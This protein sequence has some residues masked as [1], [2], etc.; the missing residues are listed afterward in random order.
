MKPRLLLVSYN[1]WALKQ[2]ASLNPG[3][4][5]LTLCW[6]VH[7][8]T[9]QEECNCCDIPQRFKCWTTRHCGLILLPI[10]EVQQQGANRECTK[11]WQVCR[12]ICS[13][14][15]VAAPRA[16]RPIPQR[17]FRKKI[18]NQEQRR[19]VRQKNH[20]KMT[21]SGERTI[22]DIPMS[23]LFPLVLEFYRKG[24]M[25]TCVSRIFCENWGTR[26][27]VICGILLVRATTRHFSRFPFTCHTIRGSPHRWSPWT[28]HSRILGPPDHLWLCRWFPYGTVDSFPSP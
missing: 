14:S 9:A 7:H 4:N 24:E 16:L 2:S 13:R 20:W 17:V 22:W 18:L 10:R 15:C 8:C 26:W 27:S 11:K 12:K 5:K 25:H 23:S 21:H 28:I 6:C 3:I 1:W 19:K